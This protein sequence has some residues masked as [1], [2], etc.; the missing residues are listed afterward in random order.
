MKFYNIIVL[1]LVLIN[2]VLANPIKKKCIVRNKPSNPSNGSI[3]DVDNNKPTDP[4]NEAP[5]NGANDTTSDMNPYEIEHINTLDK[6]L[7]EC[8]VL[9]RR[10]GDFPIGKKNKKIYLYGNGVRKTIKGGTGSGDVNSR[11]FD[12]IE[13]AFTKAGYEI[14]TKDYL[15]EYDKIY[16]K[17]QTEFND[18]LRKNSSG[19]FFAMMGAIMPEPD[20]D[21][22][23]E[24]EGDVAVFVLSRVSGE[25]SDRKP[26]KGDVYLTDTERK[27]V[28]DL[29]KGF[30]KFM[31]VLNTGG[32]VDLSG[33]EDVK[34]ILVLS[35]LGVNTSKTLV[36]IITGDKYPSGKLA[37]TWTKYEDYP[38][39]ENFGDNDDTDYKE[40]VYVGYRYFDSVNAD[41]MY[42]FGF[43]LGYT[44]FEFDVK[45]A[46]LVGEK[47]E[48]SVSVKNIGKFKGKEVLELYLSK[49]G[50]TI[51]EPYQI[52]VNF[53][54]TKELKP[55]KKQTLKLSFKLSDFASYDEKTATYI[56]DKGKYVVRVGNSSRNT[57]PCGIIKVASKVNVRKVANKLGKPEFKDFV[58][59]TKRKQEKLNGVKEFTLKTSSIKQET[60]DYDKKYEISE[61]VK[62]LSNEEK[63]KLVIGAYKDGNESVIGNASITAAGA[64]GETARVADLKPVVMADGPAGLRLSK[65]YYIDESGAHG[66][67]GFGQTKPP[68]DVE[69]LHQYTTAIPIGTAIAQSWNRQFAELCGD[70]VGSEME[71]FKIQLWLAPALNIHRS[72]LCGRNFEYYS[73]DPFISGA[74]ASSITQGVQKHNNTYVTIKHF[75]ANNQETNRYFSSSNASERALREIYLKGFE[76]AVKEANPKAIMTSYNLINGVHTS[77]SKELTSDILRNEFGFDGIVMTDWVIKMGGNNKY[78]GPIATNVVKATGDIYMPGSKSDYENILESLDNGDLSMEE[79]EISASRIYN[80]AKELEI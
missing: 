80:L 30:K 10:N 22:P 38:T 43:G 69:I 1:A 7:A 60:I 66:I 65:D 71:I 3:E 44:D 62:A 77:E 31:L 53:A 28:L 39:N 8:T 79:L 52:L 36:D 34:N 12:T 37:T 47:F 26:I 5:N 41:V 14:L 58:P 50:T 6:Y 27:M 42:P 49:P 51:D 68:K 29:A 57:K 67:G 55:N 64:A 56:L 73:E 32:P 61:E 4:A 21:I 70:I 18:N 9:L 40:G 19:N 17:A 2:L 59:E 20:Y 35:Q 16:E 48:V 46:K 63:A 15:D 45:S 24:K 74:F 54:K 72:I 23:Y 75:A 11:S 33:L 25:G 76:I 78:S 13:Q